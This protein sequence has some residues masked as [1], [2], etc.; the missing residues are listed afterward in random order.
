MNEQD[1]IRARSICARFFE[2]D[3]SDYIPKRRLDDVSRGD[4]YEILTLLR[5]ATREEGEP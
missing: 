2:N 4:L 1:K 5:Q 3:A